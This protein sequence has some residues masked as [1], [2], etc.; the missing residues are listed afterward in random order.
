MS[1]ATP[2]PDTSDDDHRLPR[3][4][5][6]RRYELTIVPDLDGATFSGTEQVEIEVHEPTAAIVLNAVDLEVGSARLVP[7]AGSGGS[8]SG[9]A[10][11][12]GS[13]TLDADAERATVTLAEEARPG[14]WYLHL[15]FAGT[16]NDKLAGFYRSTFSDD[17]GATRTIAATQFE[18]TDARRAFPCW[19]EPDRK[20][21]FSLTLVVPEGLMAVA[22]TVPAEESDAGGG[23][24]R[25]RFADTMPMSTYL[26]AYV[27]GPLEAGPPAD[28]DGV[29]LRVVHVP[30]KGHLT[31]F[32][33]EVGAHAL[34]FFS[35]WFGIA[36][37]S[38]KLDLVAIPDFAFGAMENLGAVTFRESLLLVD[39]ALASRLE[40]E[41]VAD[42]ICHEIAHMWFG[43][44]VTMRW[45]NG[46]WLNEA[47][48][49]FM[50]TIAVDAFRPEWQRW[51]SFGRSRAAAFATDGLATTRPIEYPV[52]RPSDA[53][54]MFDVLTY[55]KGASVLRMLERYLGTGPF[56][57]GIRRYLVAHSHANAETTDLWDAIE[58]AS[59]EPARA[60][61]DSW[62]FQ[63]GY[64]LV[65]VAADGRTVQLAQRPFRYRPQGPAAAGNGGSAG[66]PGPPSWQVPVLLRAGLAHG[67]EGGGSGP[68]GRVVEARALLGPEGARVDLPGPVDWVMANAG[69]SG[70]YRVRYDG[71]LLARLT[72]GGLSRLDALERF[73]LLSDTWAGTL[74]GLTGLDDLVP[75]LRLV[76]D[77]HETDP[78]VWSAV[79]SILDH[80]DRAAP[81]ADRGHV[82]AFATSLL[83][84]AWARTGWD[85]TT[86]EDERRGTLRATLLQ[87]L[88]TVAADPEVRARAGRLHAQSLAG[89][90]TMASDLAPAIVAT[91]AAAGGA[92]EYEA[93]LERYRHPSTPQEELR[94]LYALAGFEDDALVARTLELSV[95]EARTQNGPFLLSRLL[96][97]RAG[98]VATW[99]FLTERWDALLSR[100]PDNTIPRML[101]GLTALARSGLVQEVHSFFAGHPLPSGQRTVDQILERLDVNVAFTERE[102]PHLARALQTSR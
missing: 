32:A 49:T 46:L 28:V 81:E 94:Y 4:V 86:G 79:V 59:G 73:N 84:P 83:H 75:V 35:E 18:A 22:N 39:P 2:V 53:D 62:I 11:L 12:T 64:P 91:V 51:V 72:D 47:F 96:A 54:G 101:D 44:L 5:S 82:R 89:T 71:G 63:G 48:A 66:E 42:V 61:M 10:S 13:V 6:P 33:L 21:V 60:T 50:E 20:A 80:L 93:F 16:I 30:G 31:A 25:V 26:V 68:N 87:A 41:R 102:G 52:H 98:G 8:G 19:D 76:A 17:T 57:E 36:Y 34:R 85:A 74:A 37:P 99:A 43:D 45:W 15:D 65:S 3:T 77:E 1:P 38:D 69:G 70:F 67:E 29:P 7:A 55:E 9:P 92:A 78:D 23:L 56:R 14:T 88:G 90:A 95:T 97:N 100:F 40:L 27:V 24:R 58:A